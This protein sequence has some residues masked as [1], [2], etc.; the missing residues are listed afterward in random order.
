VTA[1]NLLLIGFIWFAAALALGI[2]LA[3]TDFAIGWVDRGLASRTL[4]ITAACGL[5]IAC[6]LFLTGWILPVGLGAY[7]LLRRG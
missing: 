6:L 3:R 4:A 1:R 7:R 5:V 2:W